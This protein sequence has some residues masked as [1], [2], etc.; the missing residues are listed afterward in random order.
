[1]NAV[2]SPAASSAGSSSG[3]SRNAVIGTVAASASGC[4]AAIPIRRGSRRTNRLAT[5]SGAEPA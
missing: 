5:S 2:H 3:T 4:V 1:M